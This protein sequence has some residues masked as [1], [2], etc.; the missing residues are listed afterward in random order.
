MEFCVVVIY[1]GFGITLK[2]IIPDS[3]PVAEWPASVEA[4]RPHSKK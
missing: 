2:E 4:Q 3:E 1:E